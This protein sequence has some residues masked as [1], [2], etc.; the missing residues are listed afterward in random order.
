MYLFMFD[1]AYML[2]AVWSL[3]GIGLYVYHNDHWPNKFT[4]AIFFY[5]PITWFARM[6]VKL[7]F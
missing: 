5:G 6:L 3:V 4:W 1:I 7:M 2:I